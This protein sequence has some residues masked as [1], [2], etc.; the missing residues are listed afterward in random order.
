MVSEQPTRD[1][2]YD[3]LEAMCLA[4]QVDA[5]F[6]IAYQDAMTSPK[7]MRLFLQ[8]LSDAGVKCNSED[9]DAT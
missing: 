3:R 6:E 8:A 5:A 9:G 7:R 1:E 2:F 4:G